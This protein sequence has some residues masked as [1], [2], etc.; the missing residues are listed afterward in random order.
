[1]WFGLITLF[2]D[3]FNALHAGVTGRAIKDKLLTLECWSPRDFATDKHQCVDHTP[4]G[5]GPGMV[6]MAEP[7]QAAIQAARD[8]A[9]SPPTVIYLSPQGRRFDQQ[10]AERFATLNSIILVAGRYEGI[11][12]RIIESEIDEEWSLGD[13]ILTGG[14]LAAMAMIDATSRLLPG[15][16]GDDQSVAQDSLTTGLLKYPQYT[17]PEVFDSLSVPPIL[18]SGHHANIKRWRTQQS[19]G[20]T[21]R[22]RPDLLAEKKLT[23]EEQALLDEYI[24]NFSE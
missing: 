16:I 14:E 2:P 15:V 24:D 20:R 22:R 8:A 7:L 3:M 19:L 10:A 23:Q 9:K 13:Y 12:E 5:G 4:Y 6:M 21:W 17:R 18:M 11:D 1:M